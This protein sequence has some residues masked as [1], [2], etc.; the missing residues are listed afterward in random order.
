[1]SDR[2]GDHRGRHRAEAAL[3][4]AGIVVAVAAAAIGATGDVRS[5]RIEPQV[6]GWSSAVVF[7][8]AGVYAT[9]RTGGLL[10]HLVGERTTKAAG[11]AI[12]ILVSIAGYLVVLFTTVG[13]LSVSVSR[14]LTAGAVTG[15]VLG[16]AAQQALGNVFAGMV[17][18]LARPFAVGDHIRIR[19]GSLGGIFDGTVL[20]MSLTYVTVDTEEGLLKLPNSVLLMAAVGPYRPTAQQGALLEVPQAQAPAGAP[21]GGSPAGGPAVTPEQG[22][23]GVQGVFPG[24]PP[25]TCL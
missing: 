17:L 11:S 10:G 13:L 3:A 12:R 5:A 7:A 6:V 4:A 2:E 19:S 20:G 25:D 24:T 8:L 16:I 14:I 9:R 23:P 21:A 18:L 1:M 15:V 22:S